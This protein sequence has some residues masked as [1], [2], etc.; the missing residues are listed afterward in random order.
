[1]YLVSEEPAGAQLPG[2]EKQNIDLEASNKRLQ[3]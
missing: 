3:S 2:L 1:M